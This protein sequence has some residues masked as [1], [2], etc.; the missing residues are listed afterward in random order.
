MPGM[1][2]K[3]HE[4]L[5]VC[6]VFLSLTRVSILETMVFTTII[7]LILANIDAQYQSLFS[8]LFFFSSFRHLKFWR[9]KQG[10]ILKDKILFTFLLDLFIFELNISCINEILLCV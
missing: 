4:T 8:F 6:E 2:T 1:V 10:T 9:F 7:F 3:D 5:P